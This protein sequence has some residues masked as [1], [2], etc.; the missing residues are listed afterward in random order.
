ML[1]FKE[2]A[3]TE[4][5]KQIIALYMKQHST[6]VCNCAPI[7]R[8]LL[9]PLME[10]ATRIKLK[11]KHEIS[12]L[13]A[14]EIIASKK[15][16]PLCNIKEKHGVHIGASYHNN[17]G[18]VSF[19]NQMQQIYV[20]KKITNSKFFS[21]LIDNSADSGNIDEELFI[22]DYFN[23]QHNAEDGMIHVS[24]KFLLYVIFLVELWKIFILV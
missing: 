11:Q 2:H 23:P 1:V 8:S 10:E 15:L 21:L 14:K 5:H 12:Y 6:N 4:M 24:D 18:C 17:H 7:A 16:K 9:Q 13:I 19:L 22:V 3:E 20:R